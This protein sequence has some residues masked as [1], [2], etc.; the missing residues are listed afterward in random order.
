MIFSIPHD[1][2]E[3]L[4]RKGRLLGI[5]LGSKTIGLST[6]DALWSIASPLKTLK[7]ASI[8]KD[9]EALKTLIQDENIQGLVIGW[10]ISMDGREGE[11][12]TLTQRFV[13]TVLVEMGC[14][15]LKWDERLSTMAVNRTLLEADV[16]RAKRAKV[17][18]KM[19][20]AYILQGALDR[21]N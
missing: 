16:S 8:Q 12:C 4:P 13:D 14:P 2:S 15:I 20:A 10:P 21:L 19:A 18:D 3:Q 6:A 7:R 9:T 17:V 5:D 11:R 1:F